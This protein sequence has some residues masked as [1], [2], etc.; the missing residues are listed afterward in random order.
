MYSSTRDDI[1]FCGDQILANSAEKVRPRRYAK[2]HGKKDEFENL[3]KAYFL[4]LSSEVVRFCINNARAKVRWLERASRSR[5]I[6]FAISD[7]SR[8]D[9]NKLPFLITQSAYP[10][11]CKFSIKIHATWIVFKIPVLVLD[12]WSALP[13]IISNCPGGFVPGIM[14]LY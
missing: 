4:L 2:S 1:D 6:N 5:G 7:S 10:T 11:F 8:R 13:L 12:R 14:N 9:T 3:P